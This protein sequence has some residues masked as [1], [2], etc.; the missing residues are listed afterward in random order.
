MIARTYLRSVDVKQGVNHL[1]IEHV[2]PRESK[3]VSAVDEQRVQGVVFVVHHFVE[4]PLDA[5][6]TSD[7]RKHLRQIAKHL[8]PF[9]RQSRLSLGLREFLEALGEPLRPF[10]GGGRGAF[11]DRTRVFELQNHR[12]GI[13]DEQRDLAILQ[14]G[15]LIVEHGNETCHRK[16]LVKQV[17]R[18]ILEMEMKTL[19]IDQAAEALL[20]KK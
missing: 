3:L 19:I 5:P 1:R 6:A 12:Q 10:G 13:V 17:S 20:I 4:H 18:A 2:I 11:A 9:D 16:V 7:A 14:A 15:L 8:L